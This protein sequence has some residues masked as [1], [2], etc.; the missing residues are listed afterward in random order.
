MDAIV[1]INDL[2]GNLF[3]LGTVQL[4]VVPHEILVTA[5]LLKLRNQC[6]L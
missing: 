5:S 3:Y 1:G 6:S 2:M 4:G